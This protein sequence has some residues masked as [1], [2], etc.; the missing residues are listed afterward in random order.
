MRYFSA[1][2]Y[3]DIF[4]TVDLLSVGVTNETLDQEQYYI[5]NPDPC[6]DVN[7]TATPGVYTAG[8]GNSNNKNIR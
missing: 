4:L 3:S 2:L 6:L 5:D 8:A 1:F 7:F